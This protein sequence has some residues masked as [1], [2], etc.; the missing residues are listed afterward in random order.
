MRAGVIFAVLLL[1][2]PAIARADNTTVA[3]EH[4]RI[5]RANAAAGNLDQAIV[6]FDLAARSN[7]LPKYF[8]NKAELERRRAV[9]NAN[10][11][12]DM[13]RSVDDFTRYLALLPKASDRKDVEGIIDG[14]RAR[15][16]SAEATA[17]DT[18]LHPVLEPASP[19][20]ARVGEDPKAEP[21]DGR[22][23]PIVPGKEP[24]NTP[25]PEKKKSRT[26][27][28]VLVGVGAAVLAGTAIGVGVGLSQSDAPAA[29]Y[30]GTEVKF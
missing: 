2:T 3:E 14:L 18:S 17:R 26:W 7:P 28:W 10:R 21:Q 9:T 1:V 6:E 23:V 22:A 4:A 8:Y 27:V 25:E 12:E 20:A 5:G 15:I 19:V 16:E 24:Q 30:G 11:L 29:S 13:R